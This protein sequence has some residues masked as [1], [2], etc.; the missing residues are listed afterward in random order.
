MN[1]RSSKVER[2]RSFAT[3]LLILLLACTSHNEFGS[4][5]QLEI[6]LFL[7]L[8][9][10]YSAI[11][12]GKLAPSLSYSNKERKKFLI[13]GI[14]ANR[15]SRSSDIPRVTFLARQKGNP[16]AQRF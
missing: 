12:A 9:A 3:I 8:K 6:F 11:I 15:R 10:A 16:P 2:D 4:P 14:K 1:R 13:S 7:A 5:S